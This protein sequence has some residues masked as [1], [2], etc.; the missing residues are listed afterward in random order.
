M[1]TQNEKLISFYWRW[2]AEGP[3][4]WKIKTH[5]KYNTKA[6]SFNDFTY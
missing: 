1:G 6:V 3:I 2:I 5:N 4:Q